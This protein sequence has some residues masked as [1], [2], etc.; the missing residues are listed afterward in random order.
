MRIVRQV[1]ILLAAILLAVPVA[2]VAAPPGRGAGGRF[3]GAEACGACHPAQLDAWKRTAHAR[4]A[5]PEVLGRRGRDA[6]CL[7]CHA[8]GEGASVRGRLPDVQCEACHGP[9]A[10]WAA[11]DIMRD[12]YLSRLLGLRDVRREGAALCRRCH[13]DRPP[14]SAKAH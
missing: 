10:A 8:T 11:D 1:E 3:L 7:A 4:A 2:V 6:A 9:G 12:P 13:R 14:S 5:A